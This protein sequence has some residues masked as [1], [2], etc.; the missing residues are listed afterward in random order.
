LIRRIS[1]QHHIEPLP[2]VEVSESSY[3]ST[4][5]QKCWHW[6]R[7]SGINLIQLPTQARPPR[8]IFPRT[9][10]GIFWIPL[11]M[12]TT[13]MGNQ[14]QCSVT[15]TVK[16]CIISCTGEP[17][18]GHGTPGVECNSVCSSCSVDERLQTHS[19]CSSYMALENC[20]W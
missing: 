1:P 13:S 19:V 7:T 11:R 10:P 3:R 5:S 4:A 20:I 9:C 18:T 6:K 17:R 8:T 14:Y 16:K 2:P 12:E 15:L